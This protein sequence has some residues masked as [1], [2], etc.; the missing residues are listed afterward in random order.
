MSIL[1][2]KLVVERCFFLA[3]VLCFV[4]QMLRGN[5]SYASLFLV[6]V[7]FFLQ[8]L[9]DNPSI[10]TYFIRLLLFVVLCSFFRYFVK[11][12]S[13]YVHVVFFSLFR[14]RLTTT[15]LI[16]SVTA[17]VSAVWSC[18]LLLRSNAHSSRCIEQM[19][20]S[21]SLS[22]SWEHFLPGSYYAIENCIQE[23]IFSP[24]RGYHAIDNYIQK[25][26][27]LSTKNTTLYHILLY[28]YI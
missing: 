9:L 15:A 27:S 23:A 10:R 22:L 12:V 24:T 13:G 3:V 18:S 28:V 21:L 4:W 1:K 26:L 16:T 11:I 2:K 19:V 25:S 6:A 5:R 8:M 7:C 14:V 17:T 20:L